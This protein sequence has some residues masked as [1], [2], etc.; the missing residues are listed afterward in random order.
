MRAELQH[1]QAHAPDGPQTPRARRR[2]PCPRRVDGPNALPHQDAR[3][4]QA[5]EQRRGER[6]LGARRVG[7]DG[8]QPRHDRVEV[9]VAQRVAAT[10]GVL[11]DRRAAQHQAPAVEPQAPAGP[12]QLAQPDALRVPRLA[13]DPQ[14]QRHEP[15]PGR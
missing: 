13:R 2:G 12:A 6:V 15:R 10:V 7:A 9:A 14:A 4:V 11:V 5:L 1:A 3:P 8:P